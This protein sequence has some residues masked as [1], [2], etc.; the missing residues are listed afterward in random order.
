M[1]SKNTPV[2]ADERKMKAFIITVSAIL[3]LF[4]GIPLLASPAVKSS[5]S[6]PLQAAAPALDPL[7]NGTGGSA[8]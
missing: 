2:K 8:Y 6:K 5:P 7:K 1:I 3:L 4:I